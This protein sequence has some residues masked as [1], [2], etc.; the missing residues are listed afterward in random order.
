MKYS[1]I[2]HFIG[3][4]AGNDEPVSSF[5]SLRSALLLIQRLLS[6]WCSTWSLNLEVMGDDVTA[7]HFGKPHAASATG[8]CVMGH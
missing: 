3:G 2:K 5:H 4:G 1:I 7:K 8:R 6:L